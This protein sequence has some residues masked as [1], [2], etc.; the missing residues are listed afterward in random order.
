MGP[1]NRSFEKV[2]TW[3][4][5]VKQEH[6]VLSFWKEND[7]FNKLR[8]QNRGK[9]R[10]SFLD[11]PMTANN[12]MGVHH[13]WGRSLKDAFQRYHAMNAKELRYQNGFDCQ[14]LWVEVEV[15][16]EH[17]F[18]SKKDV[19]AY[20]I[21]NF[22]NDCKA[23]VRKYSSIQRDQ[24]I[25]LGMWMD[26][27]N[28][29][30]TMSDENNYAIWAFLKKCYNQGK[31]YH[32]TDVMPWSGRSGSA[33]SQ[34]EVVEGRKFVAHPSIFVKFP[35]LEREKEN[36]LVW[37]TTPWTLTSNVA[38][39]V[40]VDLDYVKL[41]AKHDGELYYFAE[42][43]LNFKR[44]DKQY[45]EKDWI[46][47]VPRLKTIAQLFNERG[48]YVIEGSVKGAELVGLRYRGPYDH[49][50]A[51][52]MVGGYPYTDESLGESAVS[53]HRVIDG[54][55]DSRGEATVVS[56]EGT[57][58]V[59]IAPGCGDVDHGLGVK[60][61]LPM[62]APLDEAA[63]FLE[64]FGFLAGK[65]ATSPETRRMIIDDLKER[66]ILLAEELYPHVY[67]HCWRTGDELV[68]RMVDEWF[69]NMDW[70]E[71]IIK[72]AKDI[73]WIPGFGE[74][75]EIE[76]LT[77]MRD[78]MISKKRF[79]GLALPIWVCEECQH[80]EVI[81]GRE[82]LQERA[83]EG[84]E[85]FEGHS[86]H[87]PWV[88]A[89]K[90]RCAKCGGRA[91][92]VPDVGNPWLDA[93]IVPYSTMQYNT[94]RAYWEKWF[95]ADLVL[96]CFPGQFRNWFYSLLSMSAMMEDKAPFKTLLGH[97]LVRDEKGA[98]MHKST[99]NAIWFDEAA[100]EAGADVMRWLY[101][102]Q[103]PEVNLNF[104]YKPLRE[105]RGGFI[106]TLWNTYAFF[107]NYARLENWVPPQNPSPLG[108]RALFD[109]WI[110]SE[111]ALLIDKV[112]NGF[113][114]YDTRSVTLAVEAFVENLSNWYVRHNRKRF[115]KIAD[116]DP[117]MSQA[118]F[119]TLYECL[120]VLVRLVAP[121]LPFLAE[122]MYQNLSAVQSDLPESVH[123]CPFPIQ[124]PDHIDIELSNEM[125]CVMKFTGLALSAREAQ[126]L[127]LRQPLRHLALGP[128]DAQAARAAERFKDILMD[129]LNVKEI[130]ILEPNSP[131]P[132]DYDVKLNFKTAGP[133]FGS[134]IKGITAA[135]KQNHR[136]VL[137]AVHNNTAIS[138]DVDEQSIEVL[139][140]DLLLQALPNPDLAVAED[141]GS[142]VAFDT[143][144]TE[145]LRLEGLMRDCLRRFQ[146]AR[147]DA[148]LE[149][150]DRIHFVWQSEDDDIIA[151][152]GT[153]SQSMALELL[154][155][156]D[157]SQETQ[158]QLF[159]VEGAKLS[160][161]L[162]KRE[163]S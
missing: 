9:E 21:D 68:F 101:A 41:R 138:L 63:N 148:G 30:F 69:I 6:D 15:E 160:F 123:L 84:W 107:A 56:G 10:F 130:T 81:G 29:Y 129:D 31:I 75:R 143:H 49:L 60:L 80:F 83:S 23:R 65:N 154:A 158:E 157:Q 70:R 67:P 136:E 113:E 162:R 1:K 28:S 137:R 8:A 17:G 109:R 38:A 161:S 111:L 104:G 7:V 39:A 90:I 4:D 59:H 119:E 26:W 112:R 88:D 61:G 11:G 99:G 87:R 71:R 58:I 73:R 53:A 76:W 54:G 134:Q 133:K 149:I 114:N 79:W 47:G 37:T 153:W 86:P 64:P 14:G 102:R 146:M 27:E 35:L 108:S 66:S 55:R 36:L 89:V 62:I 33:Y 147:K 51:Q 32:G 152:F 85:Q 19:M 78:W 125:A 5:I 155:I 150:E 100:E 131:S 95:P 22:V 42:E 110:M 127:K 57:G 96:E 91:S 94:D 118:A 93:G 16:K 126:R 135:L 121:I 106:N 144:I 163:G 98:E 92:R 74:E 139:P 48:G 116:G 50:E 3:V 124:E 156:I 2:E 44:L 103:S 141:S 115:W 12:P 140:E 117:D 46:E 145:A 40:N 52:K 82:E 151:L 77:K 122:T 45:R 142:W 132:L 13:A 97:A 128:A 43:N 105:V 20:G 25:R 18:L 24:S 120:S 159:E 34:M 72:I